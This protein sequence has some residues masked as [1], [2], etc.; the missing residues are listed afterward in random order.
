MT[1]RTGYAVCP[2]D[3]PSS[4]GFYA[5]IENGRL[6]G[7]HPDPLHPVSPGG[8]CRKMGRYERSVNA[9]DR[10][11]FPMKRN[12]AKGSGTFVRISWDEALEEISGRWKEIFREYGSE[13]I[14]WCN[15]SGIMTPLQRS[16]GWAFFNRLGSRGLVRTL[17]ANAK[18]AGYQSVMGSVGCLDPRE[19]KDSDFLIVWSSNVPATRNPMMRQLREFREK[20]K[21]V[22]TVEVCGIDMAPF[23]D[24]L[25]LVRPGTDG[26]LALAMMHVLEREGLADR[27]YLKTWGYGYETFRDSLSGYTPE[28]AA[29]ICGV[30]AEKIEALAREYA[31]AKAPVILLGSGFSR[32]ANGGMTARIITILSQYTGAWKHPGGGLCG[33]SPTGGGYI[34]TDIVDPPEFR[35]NHPAININQLGEGICDPAVRSLYVYGS[36]PANSVSDTKAVLRGL[37]REDLFTVVHERVMTDTA[38][39]ADIILPA[40]YSVE[41]S[42]VYTAYGYCT[43]SAAPKL[44]DPPGECRSDWQTFQAMAEAMGFK[45]AYFRRTEEEMFEKL[46]AGLKGN[47]ALLPEE[48]VNRLHSGGAV[49]V[50]YADHLRFMKE[51]RQWKIVNETM[52]DPVP[53]WK[54]PYGGPESLRLIS[55]PGLWTLNSVFHER[56]EDLIPARGPMILCLHPEDA[57]ERGIVTG[58]DI[59]VFNDLA[60]VRFTAYVTE[61]VAKGAAA[62]PGVYAH[63]LT[64]S[65]LGVNALQHARL[66]DLA[67]ATTMN[68]NTVEVRKKL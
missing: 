67:E 14:A 62:A 20:G 24:E 18:G 38:R 31:A 30:P 22:V 8:L 42:D 50:P 43:L 41:Q 59:E 19:T 51:G 55:V 7:V 48:E 44:I 68:D 25:L 56:T 35:G 28:W 16:C 63:A 36:N 45:D 37:S 12:G 65:G 29:E 15:Y 4:C 34:D 64:K 11:L 5:E 26:A 9:E 47:A 39:Y 53:R 46:L 61:L 57:G 52:G 49:T 66:S 54:P 27:E 21:R 58:D 6:K 1:L 13:A 2:Y 10:I 40:A 23:S 33:C 17:C 3:C 60:C 32:Y